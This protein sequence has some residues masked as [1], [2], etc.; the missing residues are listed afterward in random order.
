MVGPLMGVPSSSTPSWGSSVL[1]RLTLTWLVLVLVLL[2][3]GDRGFGI[4]RQ[5]PVSG[6]LCDVS[7]SSGY[8]QV[9]RCFILSSHMIVQ[10]IHWSDICI[11]S[12]V[13]HL[14]LD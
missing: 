1:W 12:K 6:S 7:S 3:E 8:C 13:A 5:Q 10:L 9:G 4:Y 2:T 14:L 11:T